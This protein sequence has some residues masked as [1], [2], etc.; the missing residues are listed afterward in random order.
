MLVPGIS[1]PLAPATVGGGP[2]LGQAAGSESHTFAD[3]LAS[4][5]GAAGNSSAG[6]APARGSASSKAVS[7]PAN[8]EAQPITD[9]AVARGSRADYLAQGIV[10]RPSRISL[11]SGPNS[12]SKPKSASKAPTTAAESATTASTGAVMPTPTPLPVAVPSPTTPDPIP[13]TLVPAASSVDVNPIAVGTGTKS[14]V[15]DLRICQGSDKASREKVSTS[16]SVVELNQPPQPLESADGTRISESAQPPANFIVAPAQ[17]SD[18]PNPE[19]VGNAATQTNRGSVSQSGTGTEDATQ[20]TAVVPTPQA[21]SVPTD[22][23][24]ASTTAF[25][26]QKHDFVAAIL[27]GISS[28]MATAIQAPFTAATSE[29]AKSAPAA[30]RVAS[31]PPNAA[32]AA[33]SQIS[34]GSGSGAGS[35][36]QSSFGRGNTQS[37][38]SSSQGTVPN[39]TPADAPPPIQPANDLSATT[40]TRPDVAAAQPNQVNVPISVTPD[41]KGPV[42]SDLASSLQTASAYPTAVSSAASLPGSQVSQAHLI[43]SAGT[44]Q[45]RISVNTDALGPIE[46]QATSDKDRIGAVIAAVKPE[47]QELLI[48]E[49]PTLHQALSERNLQ[50]Q[51]VTVNQGALADGMSGRGGYS[52]NPDAWQKQAAANYWHPAAEAGPSAEDVPGTIVSVAAVPGR[53]SVHV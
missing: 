14:V 30:L 17:P 45:M 29:L 53:L 8:A 31:P 11:P 40:A 37:G 16:N 5:R 52:Q 12:A 38:S 32:S 50:I 25:A 34:S 2:A 23:V 9:S 15:P 6:N 36:S 22:P 4:V 41:G 51:Q 27:H 19:T 35:N 49:L 39:H 7:Q 28:S 43:A 1:E 47:T 3:T 13:A 42:S 21:Q 44:T 20:G 26:G 48:N 24:S 33:T 46:L 10:S 18:A